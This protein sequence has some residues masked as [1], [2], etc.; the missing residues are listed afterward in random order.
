MTRTTTDVDVVT[1]LVAL[2]DA[3]NGMTRWQVNRLFSHHR[4]REQLDGLLTRLQRLGLVTVEKDE[5]TGGRPAVRYR[6]AAVFA[7]IT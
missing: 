6:R 3:P 5:P 7:E 2:T 4:T 1:L